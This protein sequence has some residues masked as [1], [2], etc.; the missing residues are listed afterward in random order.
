ME[1]PIKAPTNPVT[2]QL[3]E[4]VTINII[5]VGGGGGADCKSALNARDAVRWR[6][7]PKDK[8]LQAGENVLCFSQIRKTAFAP[9][10]AAGEQNRKA[11]GRSSHSRG[12]AQF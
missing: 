12:H 4:N 1:L 3:H 10:A 5:G 8:K 11:T 2:Q 7:V 9:G 6:E